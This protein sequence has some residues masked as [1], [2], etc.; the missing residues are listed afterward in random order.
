MPRLF[1]KRASGWQL[2]MGRPPLFPSQFLYV[3]YKK[4]L[5]I[6]SA[7]VRTLDVEWKLNHAKSC[8][9][10]GPIG[11]KI[12]HMLLPLKILDGGKNAQCD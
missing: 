1:K 6:Y 12:Q 8:T 2:Y 3:D 9:C 5:T 7:Y 11:K 10:R 4:E